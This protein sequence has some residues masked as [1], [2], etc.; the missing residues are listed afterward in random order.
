MAFYDI[1]SLSLV[2]LSIIQ[3]VA[4]IN[5]YFSL[6]SND[7]LLYGYAIF[8]LF[9]DLFTDYYNVFSLGFGFM[10]QATFLTF[11]SLNFF[12]LK[13]IYL[14]ACISLYK[15]IQA[16]VYRCFAWRHENN[17]VFLSPSPLTSL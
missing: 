4:S 1:L 2:S 3:V 13:V 15:H 9:N 16:C 5:S 10:G 7:I 6:F 17:I 12:L 14:S 8:Y 11:L